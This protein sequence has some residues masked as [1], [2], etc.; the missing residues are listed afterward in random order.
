MYHISPNLSEGEVLVTLV[1]PRS[2]HRSYWLILS[3]YRHPTPINPKDEADMKILVGLQKRLCTNVELS[4]PTMEEL[5]LIA[6]SGLL[7]DRFIDCYKVKS[8]RYSGG[9]FILKETYIGGRDILDSQNIIYKNYFAYVDD[10]GFNFTAKRFTKHRHSVE[11]SECGL[12]F[13][14][15]VPLKERI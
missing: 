8:L 11:C 3:P 13:V 9:F 12:L 10:I 5:L 15:K 4:L 6:S 1:T 14:R 2:R 7:T